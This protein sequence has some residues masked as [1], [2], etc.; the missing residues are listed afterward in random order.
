MAREN[1]CR[2]IITCHTKDG[3]I[4]WVSCDYRDYIGIWNESKDVHG[5]YKIAKIRI[6]ETKVRDYQSI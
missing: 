3:E 5:R 1:I 2:Y 4:F 6:Q